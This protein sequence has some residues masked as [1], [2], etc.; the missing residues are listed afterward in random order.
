MDDK[1]LVFKQYFI[2]SFLASIC[3][4]SYIESCMRGE[5]SKLMTHPVEDAIYLADSAWKRLREEL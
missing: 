1:E 2:A 3:A 4:N 5:Y